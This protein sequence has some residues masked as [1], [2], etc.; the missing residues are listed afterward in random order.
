LSGSM[1]SSHAGQPTPDLPLLQ[2]ETVPDTFSF[3][4]FSFPS[5]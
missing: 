4:T 3:P 5:S 1:R 2:G